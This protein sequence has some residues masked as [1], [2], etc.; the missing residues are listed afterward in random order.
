MKMLASAVAL[1]A[2]SVSFG[3]SSQAMSE[4]EDGFDA[5]LTQQSDKWF[6]DGH[7]PVCI[8]LLRAKQEWSPLDEETATDL[9]WMYG[10][11]ERPDLE[12]LTY[13][14]YARRNAGDKDHLYPLAN[15]Y[16][17]KKSY[18]N[19]VATLS[20]IEKQDPAPHPNEFRMLAHAYSRLG[21]HKDALRV[22]DVYIKLAPDDLAAKKNRQEVLDVL[23]GKIKPASVP[24][25]PA[26]AKTGKGKGKPPIAGK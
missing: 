26:T 4:I 6:Q 15:F 3:Q 2:A 13:V 14:R 23:S 1:L 25:S 22:W 16:F 18:V 9:G 11:I 17:M 10:N 21:L 20:G 8:Q 24:D 19:V 7:F 5:R 12:W